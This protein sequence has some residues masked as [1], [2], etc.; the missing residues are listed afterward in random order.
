[1]LRNMSR[2]TENFSVSG[3]AATLE[4]QAQFDEKIWTVGLRTTVEGTLPGEKG[5]Q[6]KNRKRREHFIPEVGNWA[7]LEV[8]QAP[9]FLR[10][11]LWLRETLRHKVDAR[12]VVK[13]KKIVKNYQELLTQGTLAI[14]PV[15]HDVVV[16]TRD[17]RQK[18]SKILRAEGIEDGANLNGRTFM[19]ALLRGDTL[20]FYEDLRQS[21]PEDYLRILAI[22]QAVKLTVV[23]VVAQWNKDG[24][25][26]DKELTNLSMV[27][28]E[29]ATVLDFEMTVGPAL[30]AAFNKL[31]F[32]EAKLEGQSP[33]KEGARVFKNDE[34]LGSIFSLTWQ[35]KKS[36]SFSSRSRQADIF[37][38]EWP[39]IADG[40]QNFAK[41]ARETIP[42][43][44]WEKNWGEGFEKYFEQLDKVMRSRTM[45]L[46]EADD[47]VEKLFQIAAKYGPT[48]EAGGKDNNFMRFIVL[49]P[50][51]ETAKLFIDGYWRAT[52]HGDRDIERAVRFTDAGKVIQT[53]IDQVRKQRPGLVGSRRD[54]LI[55]QFRP[56]ELTSVSGGISES[57]MSGARGWPGW[58]ELY[59]DMINARTDAYRWPLLKATGLVNFEKPFFRKQFTEAVCW[60]FAFHEAVHGVVPDYRRSIIEEMKADL[61]GMHELIEGLGG[62]GELQKS[63]VRALALAVV[64]E[65]LYNLA[66]SSL[67][68][69]SLGSLYAVPAVLRLNWLM[70]KGYLKI[71]KDG[72]LRIV[73]EEEMLQGLARWGEAIMRK[74]Y[75]EARANTI[76]PEDEKLLKAAMTILS[77]NNELRLFIKERLPKLFLNL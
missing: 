54:W 50:T 42:S 71:N 4:G 12:E 11:G 61:F 59:I 33:S 23:D 48:Y 24:K 75:V 37:D 51:M 3:S 55:S 49:P 39:A 44:I 74:N 69:D 28:E 9:D 16:D 14:T 52:W 35:R 68:K 29:L 45:G 38:P 30:N 20:N 43:E 1:M 19:K 31:V 15:I 70:R 66:A 67:N 26:T 40:L 10:S 21:H 32:Y 47:E 77:R 17:Y 25:L 2:F 58:L 18:L 7:S 56:A 22:S 73:K 63:E 64:G 41:R 34:G 36:G 6:L 13:R 76:H 57:R 60:Y 62:I 5:S 27:K 72:G 46:K 53:T 8:D 65:D